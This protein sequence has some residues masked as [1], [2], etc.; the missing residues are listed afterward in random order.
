MSRATQFLDG[1]YLVLRN[2]FGALFGTRQRSTITIVGIIVMYFVLNPQVFKACVHM[3]LILAV[4]AFGLKTMFKGLP[5]AG[6][7]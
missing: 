7:K 5:K 2:I 3:V 4:V 6:K 1:M